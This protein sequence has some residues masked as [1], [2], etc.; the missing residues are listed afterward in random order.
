MRVGVGIFLAVLLIAGL[1]WGGRAAFSRVQRHRLLQ[2]AHASLEKGDAHWAITAARRVY[3]LDPHNVEALRILAQ[4]SEK[5]GYA[6]A[7]DWWQQVVQAAPGSVPDGIALA[8][9]AVHFKQWRIAEEALRQMASKAGELPD[10]HKVKAELAE[11]RGDSATAEKELAEALRLAG[12]NDDLAIDLALARLKE[13]A[14]EKR[15]QARQTLREFMGQEATRL[16]AARALRRDAAERRELHSLVELAATTARYPEADFADRLFQVAMLHEL[17]M[18]DF[19]E[20]LAIL[21]QEAAGEPA[22]AFALLD[23]MSTSR[24]S[25]LALEWAKTLPAEMSTHPPVPLALVHCHAAL[26][27]WDGLA[28]FCRSGNWGALE[29]LR[30]AAAARALRERGDSLE[31]RTEWAL[32]LKAATD[33]NKLLA[34]E[35]EVATWGWKEEA[36]DLLWTLA[37]DAEKQE[38]AL[39]SLYRYYAESRETGEM[40]RVAVRLLALRPQDPVAQNN[41]A[42]LALLLEV[43]RPRATEV[44]AQLYQNEPG[45]AAFASTYA[46]A[47]HLQGKTAEALRIMQSLPPEDLRQPAIAAYQGIFLASNNRPAEAA[48]YL[49]L[50]GNATLLPEEEAAISKARARLLH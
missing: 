26:H 21:Q 37:K 32:A 44:A 4:I 35:Q 19:P 41:F 42:Q 33:S 20:A 23:W 30:H 8:R 46:Y 24:L 2:Q 48:E 6:A 7:V 1:F 31:S 13:E 47:L 9:S 29:P 38:I 12:H 25:L 34:L 11:A 18:A 50:T 5:S 22:K 15:E 3:E 28:Y 14:P 10:Y 45:Q 17:Q 39:S 49:A 16:R 43:D 27:D 36:I 40:Y